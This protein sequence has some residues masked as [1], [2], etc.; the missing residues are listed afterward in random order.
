MRC[1]ETNHFAL[2]D[3]LPIFRMPRQKERAYYWST[4]TSLPYW[5]TAAAAF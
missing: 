1:E 5:K 2:L 4:S 3:L